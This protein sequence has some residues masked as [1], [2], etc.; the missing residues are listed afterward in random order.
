MSKKI[1][2]I[3]LFGSRLLVLGSCFIIV[4]C[5]GKSNKTVK[6]QDPAFLNESLIKAN[7]M[8]V[9]KESDEIDSYIRI[10]KLDMKTT[11][12]GL[13]YSIY[14]KVNVSGGMASN[15]QAMKGKY[16]RVNYRNR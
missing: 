15:E 2:F 16:A 13:R 7:M 6:I 5:G 4:S 9:K 8:Y 14:K 11:G 12:T 1:L 3:R 10:H